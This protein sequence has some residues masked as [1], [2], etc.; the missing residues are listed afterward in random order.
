ML[1]TLLLLLY[2]T[3][4]MSRGLEPHVNASHHVII[5]S[6][7]AFQC[8]T[9]PEHAAKALKHLASAEW[10]ASTL[11]QGGSNS[12]DELVPTDSREVQQ[13]VRAIQHVLSECREVLQRGEPLP[14]EAVRTWSREVQERATSMEEQLRVEIAG[15]RLSVYV[16]VGTLLV[17]SPLFLGLVAL[18]FRSYDQSRQR[19]ETELRDSEER[20]RSIA[21]SNFDVIFTADTNGQLT[22][23][24]PAVLRLLGYSRD[25]IVG[26]SI[27]EYVAPASMPQA[28]EAFTATMH[29]QTVHGLEIDLMRKD[30]ETETVDINGAYIVRDGEVAETLGVIRN[31]SD[32]KAAEAQLRQAKDAA[33]C[34]NRAKSEFLA[35][36]SHEIRTPM[37]AIIG[38]A[39]ILFDRPSFSE[40]QDAAVTIRRNAEHLL[41]L[42]NDIL[43][44]SKIESGRLMLE[45]VPCSPSKILDDVLALML[46]KAD[47]KGIPLRA[48]EAKGL[49]ERVLTDPTRLRQILVNL[50]GNAIKFTETGSVEVAVRLEEFSSHSVLRFEVTDTGIGMA[51]EQI[52][53]LFQPFAQ[54]DASTTR[55]F[56]GSGLGLVICRRLANMLGGDISV[57][58]ELGVGSTF[59]F[60]IQVGNVVPGQPSEDVHITEEM[61]ARPSTSPQSV[62]LDGC[63]ILLAEDGQDNQRLIA[64]LLR[65]AGANVEVAENGM[66]AAELALAADEPFDLILMDMQMPLKDGYQATRELR[67]AGYRGPI[68]ALTAHA[69]K[70][71]EQKCLATGCDAYLAKPIDRAKLLETVARFA[72]RRLVEAAGVS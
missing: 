21:D 60:C 46:V 69:M 71:D 70:D 7:A 5:E 59:S 32:R 9:R 48:A 34:A 58:S 72:N 39:D 54:A 63:R 61:D 11:L 24:S 62:V 10:Y 65:K 25:E 20:F 23:V 26:H 8:G 51:P 36:M 68:V 37:T 29:G 49:P 45:S 33:E 16:V 22:Y 28:L 12:H 38:F 18:L 66:V 15:D 56:G 47:A 3:D 6:S 53:R 55:K 19:A 17:C 42:I 43:D 41:T 4:R 67:A 31:I 30:G 57:E 50:V 35:N 1:A 64:F 40:A 13:Q 52:A 2:L 27:T 44:L 14:N